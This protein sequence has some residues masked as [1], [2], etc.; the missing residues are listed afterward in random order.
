MKTSV[1]WSISGIFI[2]KNMKHSHIWKN[3]LFIVIQSLWSIWIKYCF[4]KVIF[5]I[6][7]LKCCYRCDLKLFKDCFQKNIQ[8]L[9]IYIQNSTI[10]HL[11]LVRGGDT[12]SKSWLKSFVEFSMDRLH[13]F[14]IL[15]ALTP[16]HIYVKSFSFP[17][18]MNSADHPQ[19]RCGIFVPLFGLPG[20]T[21]RWVT[22]S[23]VCRQNGPIFLL[24]ITLGY[25]QRKKKS[26]EFHLFILH[27]PSRC[28]E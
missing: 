18:L 5:Y 6:S 17:S 16:S 14:V 21:A 9:I 13:A 10:L 2:I 22:C 12:A 11:I 19:V 1:I 7:V 27:V 3:R 8:S 20:R 4:C 26:D 23:D 28:L 25:V 24:F 15:K